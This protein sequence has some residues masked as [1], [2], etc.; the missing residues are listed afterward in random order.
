MHV[1]ISILMGVRPALLLL[2][3]RVYAFLTLCSLERLIAKKM[4]TSSVAMEPL[5]NIQ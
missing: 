4:I 2:S 3:A 5:K 1:F